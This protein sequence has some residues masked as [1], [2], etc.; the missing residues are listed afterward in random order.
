MYE[1]SGATILDDPKS[2]YGKSE[3]IIKVKEPLP[4]EYAFLDNTKTLLHTCILLEINKI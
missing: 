1:E 2:V 4:E 3:L